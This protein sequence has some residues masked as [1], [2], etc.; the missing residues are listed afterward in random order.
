MPVNEQSGHHLVITSEPQSRL[1]HAAQDFGRPRS[2]RVY[3][4]LSVMDKADEIRLD[5]ESELK[6]DMP[7]LGD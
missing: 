5:I 6:A 7:H 2:L 1:A 3:V 4:N